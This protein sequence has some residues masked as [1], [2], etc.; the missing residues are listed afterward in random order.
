MKRFLI[1]SLGILI[2]CIGNSNAIAVGDGEDAAGNAIAVPISTIINSTQSRLCTGAL[3]APSIVVTA[4]H[5]ILDANGMLSKFIYVGNPGSSQ[6]D[7]SKD[8]LVTAVSLSSNFR[9]AIDSKVGDDDLAFLELGS[10]MPLSIPIR[11]ASESEI[12][13]YRSTGAPLR[14]IGYG[15]YSDLNSEVVSSPRSYS[16]VFSQNP[17]QYL[18]SAYAVSTK[19]FSCVGDSG[20]PV[21]V[22]TPSTLVIVGIVTG[23]NLNH[24]CGKQAPDGSFYSL[25]TLLSRFA[26]IP[27]QSAMNQMEVLRSDLDADR[28]LE[29]KQRSQIESLQAEVAANQS[30]LFA[31][32]NLILG[33]QSKIAEIQSMQQSQVRA[34]KTMYCVKGNIRIK[35]SGVNPICP[36]G[37]KVKV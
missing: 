24:A 4:G 3:I 14:I 16:G 27:L 10:S 20:A 7:V 37:Y 34:V 1:F 35:R 26:N 12:V 32:N 11:L 22:S 30:A 17:T 29:A 9:N 36:S 18:N 33:L 2:A 23:T 28:F 31:A 5:C 25:F 15:A 6:Q 8:N 19:G 13:S 21:I